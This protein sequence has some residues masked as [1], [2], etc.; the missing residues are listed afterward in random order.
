[1]RRTPNLLTANIG[2]C[3]ADYSNLG[4]VPRG[5]VEPP[6][7]AREGWYSVTFRPTC[8]ALAC[9]LTCTISTEASY[10]PFGQNSHYVR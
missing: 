8:W 6:R 4:A 9:V 1:M 2:A 3:G 5:G 10:L 7:K